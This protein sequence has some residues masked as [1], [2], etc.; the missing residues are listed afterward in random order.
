VRGRRRCFTWNAAALWSAHGL[1]NARDALLHVNESPALVE[2]QPARLGIVAHE[3]LRA[4]QLLGEC[5]LRGVAGGR[6]GAH[7]SA[8]V[9]GVFAR[10]RD[11]VAADGALAQP[12][13]DELAA[14][15]VA[16]AVRL[17]QLDQPIDQQS[18][19]CSLGAEVYLLAVA[20]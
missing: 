16:D 6:S 15:E 10:R 5:L 19:A 4:V 18:L 9:A 20:T 1:A 13:V 17:Q 12:D 11:G 3:A 14:N 2:H 8:H 7:G